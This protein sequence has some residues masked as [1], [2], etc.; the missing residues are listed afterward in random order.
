MSTIEKRLGAKVSEVRRSQKLTQ[1]Q[2]AEKIDVSVE[3]VSRLERGVSV[4]SLKTIEHIAVSLN[5][6]LTVFFDFEGQ[7]PISKKHEREL[8]K[9]MVFLRTLKTEELSFAHEV[10][11][12]ILKIFKKYPIACKK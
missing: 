9:F 1:A 6:P 10:I 4:P 12:E 3:T 5:T 7:P 11:K 8:S 2:L